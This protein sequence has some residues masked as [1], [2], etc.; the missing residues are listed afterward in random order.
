[1]HPK[2]AETLTRTRTAYKAFRHADFPEPIKSPA[3]FA[4]QLQYD[5]NRISKSLLVRCAGG[6]RYAIVVAPMSKKVDL[7]RVAAQLGCKRVEVAPARDLQSLTDYPPNGVSPLGITGNIP[8]I[9]DDSLFI[10]DTILVGAGEAGV[11]I[12]LNPDDLLSI[13]N[14]SRISLS[15]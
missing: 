8:V 6:N 2:V 3:D 15:T 1:V 12:E 9:I 10:F 14:G 4:A 5:L 13:T 7:S 11:E